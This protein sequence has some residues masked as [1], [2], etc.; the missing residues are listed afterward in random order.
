[1]HSLTQNN[2]ATYTPNVHLHQQA[3]CPSDESPIIFQVEHFKPSH[4]FI[5]DNFI[6][7]N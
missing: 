4:T 5:C 6:C 3:T 2:K 7:K 1:M